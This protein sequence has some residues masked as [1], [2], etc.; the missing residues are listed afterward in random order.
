MK[1]FIA[2]CFI[3]YSYCSYGQ[4]RLENIHVSKCEDEAQ[5]LSSSPTYNLVWINDSILQIQTRIISNCVGVYKPRIEKYGSILNLNFDDVRIDSINPFTNKK[6]PTLIS[7]DCICSF[8]IEWDIFGIKDDSACVYLMRGQVFKNYDTKLLDDFFDSY[9][10][11]QG[12]LG[13]VVDKNQN[14]QWRYQTKNGD[15]YDVKFYTDG[16]SQE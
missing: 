7:Y 15:S 12:S 8:K 16:V 4:I 10:I 1:Y 9:T 14:R 11:D 5:F 13:N 3:F 6:E 2:I